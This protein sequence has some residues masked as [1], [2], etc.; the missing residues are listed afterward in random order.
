MAGDGGLVVEYWTGD[1]RVFHCWCRGC[2]WAG[3][4]V[5]VDRVIGHEER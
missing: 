3:E 4:V 5:H 2:G 1:Q